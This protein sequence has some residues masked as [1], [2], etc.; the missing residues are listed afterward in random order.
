MVASPPLVT[1]EVCVFLW[2]QLTRVCAA[3]ERKIFFQQKIPA[4]VS[5]H[6]L[7]RAGR[8]LLT[9]FADPLSEIYFCL[10][11]HQRR[12]GPRRCDLTVLSCLPSQ[13]FRM[14]TRI[15]KPSGG[16]ER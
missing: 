7:G 5:Q 14:W 1:A 15:P 9:Q 11:D 8:G 16:H 4:Q 12:L 10:E 3:C 6:A 2:T 13:L